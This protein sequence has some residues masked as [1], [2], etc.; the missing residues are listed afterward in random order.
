M[1]LDRPAHGAYAQVLRTASGKM[2]TAFGS[3]WALSGRVLVSPTGSNTERARRYR[4]P[5]AAS[6]CALRQGYYF[7]ASWISS[8]AFSICCP[9]F[10]AALSTSLPARSTEPSFYWQPVNPAI[11]ALIANA[12]MTLLPNFIIYI[13]FSGGINII[14]LTKGDF[15]TSY[16]SP[17]IQ[18]I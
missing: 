13:S 12:T 5:S 7:A 17:R 14:P 4:P 2:K 11:R 1:H 18:T 3:P 8:P 10:S 9:A 15:Y 6:I 16:L